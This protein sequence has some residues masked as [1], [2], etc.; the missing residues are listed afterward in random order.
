MIEALIIIGALIGIIG[1]L[2]TPTVDDDDW[3]DDD[4]AGFA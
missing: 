2:R 4:F 1:V 3:F